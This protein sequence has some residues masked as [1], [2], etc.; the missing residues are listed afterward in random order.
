MTLEQTCPS[1]SA[2]L[3]SD[4]ICPA[5]GSVTRGFFRGLNL[6]APQVA[7]AVAQGLDL[8]RLLGVDQHAD[9]ITIARQYR[10]LRALF[11]DDPS[12]LAAEPRR[13][14]ELLQVAGRILTDPSLRALYNELRVSAAAGIQQGVVRCESCGAPLQGNEPRCRYCGSLRPGEPAPPATPPDAGPPVAEPVDFY[15]LL[16]LS[17]AHLMINPGARRSARPALDAAE[18]L[19]ESRPPTPEEVDAASYAF[20]QRTLLHH[21]WSAAEREARVENLEIARRILRNERLRNR[22]D[23]FW[24]AFR[25]G[26]FDHG[27][28]EG[29]RALIDEVRA[30]E[31]TPSTLSVEEAEALFQQGRG[32]LTAGLPREAL[33]PLSRAREALPHSAEAHAWYARAVLASA[34]PLDLGGHALRQALV[35]LETAA[36]SGAPLPDSESYLALCR[37]LLARDAGDARQAEIELLRAAQQNP[38]LAHAWRGLAALAL[39]R[40]ANGDAIDH[41][42]RA[43]AIDPRDERAWL[44]L[45]GAC[46]RTR[47]HAEARA[48]A[49]RVAALRSDGVSAEKILAEIAN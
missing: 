5:C 48:A 9:A 29:L 44:M 38:S 40:G 2:T 8:Y 17:P 36:R 49:E 1:C 10:R 4:G 11:P 7:A 34:D 33:D 28:L 35:A 32:L 41:C 27:H 14:F 19:H 12:A 45:A 25:Q 21:G 26:R 23:A 47:R 39:A 16:G 15:A 6:G 24:L 3:G 42:H 46:L 20:Q 13:K 31:T 43:L 18:M 22:Y 37:G 30:D